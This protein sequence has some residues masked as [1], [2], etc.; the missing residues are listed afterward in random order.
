VRAYGHAELGRHQQHR[1]HLV[2]AAD[3][4]GVDLAGAD[5]VGLQQLLEDDPVGRDLAGG[6]PAPPAG[7]SATARA[8]RA[9]PE[10][11]VGVGR[12][13][14]PVRVDLGQPAMLAIASST[15]QTWLASIMSSASGP[16]SSRMMR[17]RRTSSSIGPPTFIFTAVQPS[18]TAARVSARTF[19]SG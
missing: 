1:E 4:A 16:I 15:S 5:R 19:S 10:H 7:Q 17:A 9:W 6:H 11:V 13:L 12:L 18:A 3:A 8:I 2:D 14:D